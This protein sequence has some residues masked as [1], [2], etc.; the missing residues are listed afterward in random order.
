MSTKSKYYAVGGGVGGGI[1]V[2]IG[3]VAAVNVALLATPLAPVI[4]LAGGLGLAG[5]VFLILLQENLRPHI[6]PILHW[7]MYF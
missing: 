2:G 7:L 6:I 5:Y 1:G 3:G 4:G